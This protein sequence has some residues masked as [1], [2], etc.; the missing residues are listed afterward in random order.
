VTKKPDLEPVYFVRHKFLKDVTIKLRKNN[1]ISYNYLDEFHEKLADYSQQSR[2]LTQ[3]FNVF[4]SIAK[5][6]GIVVVDYEKASEFTIAK[7]QI[8]KLKKVIIP[9]SGED[10]V[11]KTLQISEPK[12]LLYSD[13]PLIAAIRPIM[14]TA[15]SPSENFA[16]I[17]RF[18]YLGTPIEYGVDFMHPS[19]VEVMVE[20]FLRSSLANEKLRLDYT[21]LHTG[22]TMP[23]VDIYG[24]NTQN[25]KIFVQVTNQLVPKKKLEDFIEFVATKGTSILFSKDKKVTHPALQHHFCLGE[26]FKLLWE[27]PDKKYREILKELSGIS[28]PH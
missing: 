13:Y 11:Y 20:I 3:A 18:I 19:S 1:L 21:L 2:G 22:K 24:R 17:A 27:H 4:Q 7:V 9:R 6:G 12:T 10:G 16:R 15:C 8:Q 14:S 26:I 23:F 5:T 28:T 25:E